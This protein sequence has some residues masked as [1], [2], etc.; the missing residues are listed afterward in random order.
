MAP[1]A[2]LIGMGGAGAAGAGAA[3]AGA[4]GAGAGAAGAGA[5][6]AG[7]AGAGT[8]A[9][10][11][12]AA[13]AGATGAGL[14]GTIATALPYAQAAGQV[15]NMIGPQ[16][17]IARGDLGGI[18]ND[19]S[20]LGGQYNQLFGKSPVTMGQNIAG[21]QGSKEILSGASPESFADLSPEIQKEVLKVLMR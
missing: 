5:L 8:A 21:V 18:V 4:L 3:G 1:L 12:T 16:G 10:L 14:G 13:G 19:A 15:M 7:A 9:G 11:G 2:G 17:S 6:G 20:S